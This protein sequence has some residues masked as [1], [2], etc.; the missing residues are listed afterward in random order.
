[1]TNKK[2]N[3]KKKVSAKKKT[4]KKK[5]IQRN[6][7]ITSKGINVQ[8]PKKNVKKKSQLIH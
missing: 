7:I 1:M 6:R 3:A 5:T 8:T 4:K 2:K